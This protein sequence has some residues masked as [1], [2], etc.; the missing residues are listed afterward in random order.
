MI[1][2]FTLITFSL[3]C[4]QELLLWFDVVRRKLVLVNFNGCHRHLRIALTHP[5]LHF[6]GVGGGGALRISSDGDD[7]RT[8]L[9]L[10][11]S[12][13]GFFGVGKFVKYFLGVA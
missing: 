8:S 10:R 11:S 2:L 13:L 9:G 5:L 3:D 12:I 4:G 7:R 1:S 6:Q